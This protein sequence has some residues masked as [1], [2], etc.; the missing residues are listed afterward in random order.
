[1]AVNPEKTT[2]TSNGEKGKSRGN[3]LFKTF[4]ARVSMAGAD[5]YLFPTTY[6]PAHWLTKPNLIGTE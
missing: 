4:F 3:D 2:Q 5:N 1:V 6:R